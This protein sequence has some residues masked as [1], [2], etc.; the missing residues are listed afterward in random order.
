MKRFFR[1][2]LGSAALVFFCP[3]LAIGAPH[4]LTADDARHLLTRT[5]FGAA[6]QEIADLIGQ[7]RTAAID[8]LL[9]DIRS[10]PVTPRPAWTARWQY[11]YA[12]IGALGQTAVELFY[13]NR[14]LD[15]LDLQKW[16]LAEM[17]ATP[18]PLTEKLVLFWHDHFATS[19]E[20]HENPHWMAAQNSFF[21]RHAAG[22]FAD[23]ARGILRDPA[24][25]VYLTNTENHREAPNENLA[26]EYFELFMLGEG[27][28]YTEA[29]VKD[30]ARALTGHTVEDISAPR[31][32]FE[33]EAHDTATKTILGETGPFDA[34][35]LAELAMR[36][37]A[38]GPHIVEALW[39]QFV[40]DTPQSEDVARLVA[41][42]RNAD[43]E[44]K[45][46]LRD[47]FLSDAF[48]A[49]ESRGRLVKSP[50]D[51]LIGSLRSLGL[52][53]PDA[54][55]LN[56][57]MEELGQSLFFP[58]NVGGWP[59]GIGWM[60]D[61]SAAAR[62]TILTEML[63]LD[64]DAA[65]RDPELARLMSI[66]PPTVARTLRSE[67][68][69]I[70]Q[71][72]AMEAEDRDGGTFLL[73]TL[74]DVGFGGQ[75]WRSLTIWMELWPGEDFTLAILTADCAPDCLAA[76]PHRTEHDA[77]WA[78]IEPR[79]GLRR[80]LA[81]LSTEDRALLRE[82]LGNL[83][84]IVAGTA[85]QMI[86]S[87]D[88]ASAEEI[89]NPLD[90]GQ[91]VAALRWLARIAAEVLGAP[92]G[93]VIPVAS[94]PDALGLGGPGASQAMMTMSLEDQPDLEEYIEAREA[95]SWYPVLPPNRYRSA[96]A[97]LDALPFEG[98][99]SAR[100]E[101]ALLAVPLPSDGRRQERIA[102]DP[103]ALIRRII[104]S[105][106]FQVH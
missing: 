52:A 90:H 53:V 24:M 89:E 8:S 14:W 36:H 4:V 18:S 25:L 33:P 63:E 54:G 80:D 79:H 22:N 34:P 84:E 74:F 72:F 11:P 40:S 76:W 105:P 29:D 103:E 83:P 98:L 42:W 2:C 87:A 75:D 46:L 102:T 41:V 39:R 1:A 5:G 13:T 92:E 23:L 15:V 99:E 95:E 85:G 64:P 17:V 66:A 91:A 65:I 43:W 70:G 86:W 44:L 69:R 37:P 55:E 3:A 57:A 94:D 77:D 12:Q 73:L 58:P 68:L 67:D 62:A 82:L 48:W 101:A 56:W 9:D 38:F 35:D 106:T 16:W 71:V 21:R 104:L 96:R 7:P 10:E 6:P 78:L 97:W 30:A 32:R 93:R 51:L 61:A 81:E 59:E 49:A 50:A 60:T 28:G 88:F 31:Y 100:A 27:R 20:G 45:P 26:R 19:F 47:L